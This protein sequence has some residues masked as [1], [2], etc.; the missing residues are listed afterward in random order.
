MISIGS[1]I[2]WSRYRIGPKMK[3][4]PRIIYI[5]IKGV[6]PAGSTQRYYIAGVSGEKERQENMEK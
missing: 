2:L 6:T 3:V 4:T 1:F 5:I